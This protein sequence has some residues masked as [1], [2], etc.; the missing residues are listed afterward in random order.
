MPIVKCRKVQLGAACR[1]DSLRQAFGLTKQL[2]PLEKTS[3]TAITDL[4][5]IVI[6]PT[7]FS[8]R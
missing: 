1:Y 5:G 7:A 2:Q 4:R 3:K 8:W 6:G